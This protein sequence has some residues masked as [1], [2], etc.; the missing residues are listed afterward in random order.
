[1]D[2]FSER[3][4]SRESIKNIMLK[5]EEIFKQQVHELHRLYQVQ[6]LLMA[7][8]RCKKV[9]GNSSV[10]TSNHQIVTDNINKL[11]SRTSSETTHSSHG[12]VRNNTN[13]LLN[14]EHA[15]VHQS[16]AMAANNASRGQVNSSKPSRTSMKYIHQNSVEGESPESCSNEESNLD[17][18]LRINCGCDQIKSTDWKEM[19]ERSKQLLSTD[20]NIE[21]SGQECINSSSGF[22][23]QSL[24]RP[25]WLFQ[26][27][28]LNRT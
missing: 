5:Q 4:S 14:Y 7:E 22:G 18:T 3:C 27:L 16:V 26:A 13:V 15:S 23:A 2:K 24:K 12:S 25:H 28:S 19:T 6:K 11:L 1:M 9:K 21:E 8:Q 20:L 10:A 17:L